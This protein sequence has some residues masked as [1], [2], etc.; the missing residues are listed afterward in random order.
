MSISGLETS[1]LQQ[2]MLKEKAADLL[3]PLATWLSTLA[4]TPHAEV[5]EILVHAQLGEKINPL[6]TGLGTSKAIV[7][8]KKNSPLWPAVWI[9]E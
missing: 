3:E 4:F 1:H 5:Y 8:E 6:L 7:G 2:M 9:I